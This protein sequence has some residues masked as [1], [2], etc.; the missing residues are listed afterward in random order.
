MERLGLDLPDLTLP[1]YLRACESRR[2]DRQGPK[3][4]G[5]SVS[6]GLYPIRAGYSIPT[7]SRL[8]GPRLHPQGPGGAWQDRQ[9]KV[10]RAA[11]RTR[12]VQNLFGFSLRFARNPTFISW[13]GER[14]RQE[15]AATPQ[16]SSPQ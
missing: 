13:A 12:E 16:A 2:V 4:T 11:S 8:E 6:G 1:G 9:D 15:E 7:R 14:D 10:P 3:M 5:V